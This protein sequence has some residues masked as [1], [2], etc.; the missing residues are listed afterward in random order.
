VR[1]KFQ[2][3][4]LLLREER[5]RV[6]A[7][8]G[9]DNHRAEQLK[10]LDGIAAILARTAVQDTRLMALLDEGSGVSDAARS[11]MRLG[12]GSSKGVFL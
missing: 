5:A 11:L 7:A 8:A 9:S 10:R 1:A 2:A 12:P 4:A 6:W 3:V